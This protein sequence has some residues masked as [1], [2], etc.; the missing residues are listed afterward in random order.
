M[1]LTLLIDLD[2]TLLS[3]NIYTFLPVYLKALGKHLIHYVSP[4]QMVPQLLAAT[5]VMIDNNSPALTLE[6][7][8]DQAFYPAIGRSKEEM[9][10]SLATFYETIFPD[11]SSL[12]ASRPAAVELVNQ[13]MQQ[14]H[15]LV[16]ATNP[17][18]P[19]KAILHRL[20]WAGLDPDTIPF[21]MITD[22]SNFHYAKPNPAF[23][24][25][26]LAQI[27]WPNQPAV[28]I[29][30]D[31]KD[32]LNPA[33]KLGVPVFWLSEPAATLPEGLPPYSACGTLEE[34]PA[35]IDM[36]NSANL[37]QTFLAPDAMLAI[38]KS[39]PAA[40]DTMSWT[41]SER[42]WRER[43]APGEWSLTEIFCHLR[44][45]DREV[46]L[47]RIEKVIGEENPFLPGINTDSWADERDY[48]RQDG[49]AALHEFISS[50][51]LLIERLEALS[52]TDWRLAARHAIFGPTVLKELVS[53]ITTHDRSHIQQATETARLLSGREGQ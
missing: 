51:I 45:V 36:V 6:H 42:Q 1:T 5:Q 46:N 30:N 15:T 25:E 12:T 38:L 44:D 27:G 2:D 28:V 13:A 10:D 33:A 7:A 40:L 48:L 21:A 26:I 39:T 52:D 31:L 9:L 14:G 8:F 24:S 34:V 35:W 18:F 3:N 23:F 43:P 47:P 53:F 49:V 41:L 17:I 50:R 4:E 22:Y 16:V 19:R 11:L 37:R 20:N 32:D 29:G